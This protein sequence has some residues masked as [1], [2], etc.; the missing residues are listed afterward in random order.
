MKRGVPLRKILESAH[1]VRGCIV[2]ILGNKGLELNR[3]AYVTKLTMRLYA[4]L[5]GTTK[6]S[7]HRDGR[8]FYFRRKKS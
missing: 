7:S 4:K 1:K 5:G 2:G 3:L 6:L 8:F